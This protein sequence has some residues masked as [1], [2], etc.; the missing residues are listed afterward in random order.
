[1]LDEGK[2]VVWERGREEGRRGKGKRGK[3][4]RG[5][6]RQ[7]ERYRKNRQAEIEKGDTLSYLSTK[8]T[9]KE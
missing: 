6:E 2:M 3:E 7:R 4:G 9:T 5:G 8:R 1:M